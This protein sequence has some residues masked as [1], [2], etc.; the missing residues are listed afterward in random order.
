VG[1]ASVHPSRRAVLAAAAAAMIAAPLERLA[2]QRRAERLVVDGLDT[3]VVNDGFL[4]LVRQGD[5]D[6][7]HKTLYRLDSFAELHHFVSQR[8]DRTTVATTVGGI[9]AA[10]AAGRIAFV[11]GVQAAGGAYG[12]GLDE[13]MDQA[14]LGSLALLGPALDRYYDQGLRIQGLCYNGYNVFGSGCLDHTVPLTRAGRRLVEEIHRRRILLDVG[15]HT[16]ERTSLDAIE[17]SSGAPVVVTHTNFAALNP[18]IRCISDRLAER[19]AGT[20]G[21]VGLTAVSDFLMRSARVAARDGPI[22]PLATL[23][24]LLDDFDY[25]KRLVGA[26]HLGLG[27]DFLWGQ[28]A[29]SVDPRDA[30]TFTPESLSAGPVRTVAGFEDISKLGNLTA[31]LRRRGWTEGELDLVLGGSWLRVYQTAWGA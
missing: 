19:V 24:R 26:E 12:N 28:G 2:G 9:R 13:A 5:A 21:V 4:N 8:S 11:L 7:V 30:A 22:S 18:N 3:S 25:G 16:G 14:P 6:C 20:G 1:T 31:G 27:P 23:D 15:G 10:R 29:V 17:L